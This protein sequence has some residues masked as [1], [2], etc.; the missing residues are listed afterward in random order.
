M[1]MLKF[2]LLQ[3]STVSQGERRLILWLLFCSLSPWERVGERGHIRNI[4]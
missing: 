1:N 2:V 4:A 3:K